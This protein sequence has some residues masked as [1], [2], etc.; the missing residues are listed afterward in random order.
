MKIVVV[1]TF[2]KIRRNKERDYDNEYDETTGYHELAYKYHIA[3]VLITHVKKEIDTN[4]PFDSIYG[5][6]GLTA[7]SDQY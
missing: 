5:S 2:Q 6:R 1:D 4:H 7:G 3:I